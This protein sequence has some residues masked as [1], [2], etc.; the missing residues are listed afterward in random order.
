MPTEH[1]VDKEA[2]RRNLAYRHMHNIPYTATYAVVGG[3]RHKVKHSGR[4]VD[5]KARRKQRKQ[6]RRR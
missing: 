4:A 5:R 1:F 6:Q 2:E 3:V